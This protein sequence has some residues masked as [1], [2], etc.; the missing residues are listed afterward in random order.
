MWS[1][2][3]SPLAF[4][5]CQTRYN[6]SMKSVSTPFQHCVSFSSANFTTIYNLVEPGGDQQ[7]ALPTCWPQVT[8]QLHHQTGSQPHP[9]GSYN[10]VCSNLGTDH[11]IC[12][13]SCCFLYDPTLYLTNWSQ[14]KPDLAH[15]CHPDLSRFLPVLLVHAQ[16]QHAHCRLVNPDSCCI[17][18]HLL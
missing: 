13:Q 12:K 6:I 15:T 5:S 7:E 17:V 10:K 8:R 18:G 4:G 3:K 11:V 9:G 1:S 16:Y 14:S 2:V